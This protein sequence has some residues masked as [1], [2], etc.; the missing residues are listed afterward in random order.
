MLDHVRFTTAGE[1]H[2]KGT[3]VILEGMPAGL[4]LEPVDIARQL[5][6]RQ[7][8]Y[9][10]GGRMAIEEDVGEV[11]SGVRLGETLGSPLSFWI[12]ND[13]WENWQPAMSVWPEPD[14]TDEELQRVHLPRPG[15]AD[16]VGMLKYDRADARDVL[17][18]SSARE[19]S[20]RVAA[21]AV[22]RKLLS[23]FGVTLGSHVTIL[24]GVEA[25]RPDPL[26]EDVN[27]AAAESPVRC[28]DPEASREMVE[29]IDAAGSRGDTVGGVFEVV[30]RG[31][32]VGLGSHVSWDRRLDGRLA[33]ALMSIQ[34]QKGVEIGMGFGVAHRRGSQVHDEIERD[35]DRRLS[36]GYRRRRNNAGG[37]EG[38]TTTGEPVVCRVAMKPLSSLMKPLDSVDTRTGEEAE[39][40]RERSDICAVPAAGV[41]GEA[42]VALVLAD[43][44]REKFGGDSMAEMRDN[45]GAY[46]DRVNAR[47]FGEPGGG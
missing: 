6:R 8:G 16:L 26:P 41:V 11:L 35:P 20:A 17:E 44:M 40:I 34:A 18:R 22:A 3:L 42:M 9:G 46:L 12:G 38:G 2:G 7:G 37:T 45:Y 47:T 13:D 4:E 39:A 32:P 43:A 21:G 10:R 29:A 5:A 14:A 33:G 27:A 24:G 30:A 36:G 31:V 28:L 15:H 25:E 19:T 1:S 23:E